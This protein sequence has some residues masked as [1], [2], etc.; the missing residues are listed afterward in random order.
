MK[1]A[2]CIATAILLAVNLCSAKDAK[3]V[4]TSLNP[5]ATDLAREVGGVRV[6]VIELMNSN[7]DPHTFSPDPSDLRKAASAKI[8]LAMGK[9]LETYLD[10]IESA[11]GSDQR[12]FEIGRMV[13]SLRMSRKEGVFASC[14]HHDHGGSIDPHWWHSP[15]RMRK[16]A[17]LLAKRL[18]DGDPDGADQ[19]RENAKKYGDRLDKLHEWAQKK[20]EDIPRRKRILTT[21]HAAFN[22][23]CEE[24]G[25][26]ALPVNGLSSMEEPKPSEL[27]EIIDTI[28][29]EDIPA[30]F[31]EST[32][33]DKMLKSIARETDVAIG[34]T[35]YS[36]TL[37][38]DNPTYIGLMRHNIAAISDA[39]RMGEG[40]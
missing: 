10:D 40:G 32:T 14:P 21:S 18:A 35:L 29:S 27:A 17:I 28:K 31:P 25:L 20:I 2:I 22:Y 12:I 24:Y 36:G 16:A 19:Y 37:P 26:K 33:S 9:G 11:L 3:L 8:F 34:D 23:L 4:L 30:I 6:Q 15:P 39:L 13:P 1:R 5:I 7:Q 38:P